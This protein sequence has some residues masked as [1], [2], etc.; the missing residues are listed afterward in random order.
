LRLGEWLNFLASDLHQGLRSLD[1]LQ[2]TA[3][4]AMRLRLRLLK[5]FAW[6]DVQLSTT[7][8]LMEDYSVADIYLWVLTNWARASWIDSVR[9]IDLDLNPFDNICRWHRRIADRPAVRATLEAERI[10]RAGRKT[11]AQRGHRF[12]PI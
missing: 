12:N 10:L 5:Y 4:A 1:T 11:P 9:E 6:V 3:A 8:F 7:P 2:T